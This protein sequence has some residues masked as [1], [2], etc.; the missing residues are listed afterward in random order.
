VA[1][2]STRRGGS[3]DRE[4]G[5]ETPMIAQYLRLKE[6]HPGT[7]L[8]FRMG[9]FY[10]LFFED[11][12][13]AA[14]TLDIA[15]TRRGR[16]RGQD[17][18][19]AGV[20][21][22]SAESY[23]QR[24]IRAGFRVAVC[25]QLEDPAEARK[26]G[27]KAIVRRDVVRIVTPGTLYEE[28]LLDARRHNYLLALARVRG[29]FGLARV[30]VST[31]DF[32]TEPVEIADLEAALARIEPAEL[33]VPEGLWADEGLR[34]GLAPWAGAVTPLD[35]DRFDP[36]EGVR[37]LR[38]LFGVETPEPFGDF[39]PAELAA[40]AALVHYLDL[41]QKGLLPR[42]ARPRRL[43]VGTVL[44]IDPATRRNLEITRSLGGDREG[45]LLAAVDR[46]VTGAG[47]RL[48]AE[49]LAAP[50]R[51]PAEIHARLDR[52]EAFVTDDVR[53]RGVRERL[54]RLPDLERAL[55][56]LAAGRGGPRDL[57][58]VGRGL[59]VAAEIAALL[60]DGPA[61]LARL[62]EGLDAGADLGRRLV[63]TLVDSP[64]LQARDGGFVR[65]E[66]DPELAG[67]VELRDHGRRAI[68]ALEA[69]YR[70]ET[71]IPSLKIRHNHLLG[72]Y[73]E[74]TATHRARVPE[75][76]VQRQSMAN[77]T[78][79]VTAELAEL[80]GRLARAAERALARELALF[81]EL[82]RAVLER[83]GAVAAIARALAEID[84]A[85]G[86]AELAA[87]ERWVRP[88]LV[89]APVLRIRGGRH[90]VVERALAREHRPFVANDCILEE[91]RRL[92]LLTGPNM[93]GKS[94]FLRQNALLVVLAQAGSFVP[95]EEAE[96][97]LVD[98]LFSRVGASDELA[99][100]RSTFM[101]EM[102][103]T[104][105]ILHRA[106]PR[107]LVVL[108][109][110]GRGTATFDGLSIAWAVVEYLHDVVRCR[111]LFATH[112]HELT[113]LV[114]RL[115][116]LA[117]HTV[118]VREW[119]GEVV[120]LHQVVPGAADRSYGI[121]VA[122]LAGLPG[123]VVARARQVLRR[124]EAG[125]ARGAVEELADQLPLFAA[126]TVVESARREP[127]AVERRLAAVDPDA[128]SPREA[129]ELLY[130]LRA[131]LEADGLRPDGDAYHIREDGAAARGEVR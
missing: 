45:S 119:K 105:T 25:E 122:R 71:G 20:P 128:L 48:L 78:R 123:P 40:A 37:R 106:T 79:Y 1:R 52:V 88:K 2:R 67:L 51:E 109:E 10:E 87:A 15:L 41:T 58:A 86:L 55:G 80:E 111:A 100:G 75:G 63:A 117:A 19:M 38:A 70:Q 124:L 22:H 53:R 83:G 77:A 84:V 14:R 108:D 82:R 21:V 46:T 72:Y 98:R 114:D 99:R 3:G 9:D 47:G 90:P 34:A 26:R 39:G 127:S 23:L 66:A 24:L 120:F 131:L 7:L 29:R 115:P 13:I 17:I 112:Y 74:V 73:V 35:D 130:E 54:A 30:D 64:P 11:A 116:D 85:A 125:A 69:R 118:A 18:P 5:G 81:E 94:T 27:S 57:L 50:S 6:A 95:A 93:A 42:L 62:A 28:G 36:R 113:A 31:G 110:I 68:A 32:L 102:L 8:F 92:W 129:L 61:P 56:R 49:R 91:G 121:H 76:F 103:E 101:V 89:E 16:W 4:T 33:L 60:A 65:P 96:I 12:E 43:T 44:E 104:A 59:G 107:S 126:M 97:G